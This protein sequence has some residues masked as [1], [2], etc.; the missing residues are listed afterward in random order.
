MKRFLF[1]V[2][3]TL[4]CQVYGS[5]ILE[6]GGT[7]SANEQSYSI[8]SYSNNYIS[9][10]GGTKV[11]DGRSGY[12]HMRCRA[13]Q[14]DP[15]NPK[16]YCSEQ[17]VDGTL[18]VGELCLLRPQQANP[19]QMSIGKVLTHCMVNEIEDMTEHELHKYLHSQQVPVIIGPGSPEGYYI[20]DKHHLAYAM[21]EANLKFDNSVQHRVLY[22]CIDSD[23]SDKGVVDFWE[24]LQNRGD[25]WLRDERGEK[26]FSSQIPHMVKDLADDP[27]RTMSEWLKHGNAYVKCSDLE[28]QELFQCINEGD[29]PFFLEYEWA[30]FLRETLPVVE[31]VT[32]PEVLPRID[33]F[34]YQTNLQ[35]QWM[36]LYAQLKVT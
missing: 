5:T 33:S 11:D 26:I 27:Y 20:T 34:I 29:A 13:K 23:Y 18:A 7:A 25:V 35:S 2:A 16:D 12:L 22:A 31:D 9:F 10:D 8:P 21:L 28:N 15:S 36:G 6:K 19:T 30:Q 32:I 1:A 24:N 4:L 17:Y 14:L 3:S